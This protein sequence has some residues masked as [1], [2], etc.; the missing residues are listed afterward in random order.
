M[1]LKYMVK[2]RLTKM[3]QMLIRMRILSL[4]TRSIY[5]VVLGLFDMLFDLQ[6]VLVFLRV[7]ICLLGAFVFG[8]TGRR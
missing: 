7:L 4:K 1:L 2:Q 6:H 5:F 8:I 3:T